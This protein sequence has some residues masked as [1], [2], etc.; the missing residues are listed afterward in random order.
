MLVTLLILTQNL[1]SQQAKVKNL[2]LEQCIQIALKNN[3][4]I[5]ESKARVSELNQNISQVRSGLYPLLNFNTTADRL[6]AQSGYFGNRIGNN[7]N[8]SLSMHYNFYKGGK[9]LAAIKVAKNNYEAG[10]YDFKSSIE[11]LILTVV[12]DYYRLLLA[13]KFTAVAKKSL[14][15][16]QNHLDFANAR[17]KNGLASRSDILKAKTELSNAKL[18]LITSLNSVLID[19]GQLNNTLG[20]NVDANFNIVDDLNVITAKKTSDDQN[21]FETLVEEAHKNRPELKKTEYQLAAQKSNIQMAKTDYY[22]SV[23]L[24]AN[25]NFDGSALSQLYQSNYI[26]LSV[27]LPLFSGF[28]RSSHLKQEKLHLQVLEKQTSSIYQQINLE[29]WNAFRAL[30]EAKERIKSTQVFLKDARENL[31]LSEGEYKE[32][33]GSMLDVIDAETTYVTAEQTHIEASINYKI[34]QIN[35]QRTVS[36]NY[37]NKFI[38]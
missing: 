37:F 9:T 20:D 36:G 29:V 11:S 15:S 10:K 28:S 5:L 7:Y 19:R 30:K 21:K 4:Q 3:P 6:S 33:L 2:N 27:N 17:F 13:E 31:D 8:T 25:Y 24:D 22:P 16:S 32:G 34:G 35:L 12:K 1:F 26:G 23:S 14:K 18:N 38:K